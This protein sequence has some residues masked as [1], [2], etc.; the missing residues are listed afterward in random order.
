MEMWKLMSKKN[1]YA[2][3]EHVMNQRGD[4][5]AVHNETRNALMKILNEKEGIEFDEKDFW[6]TPE[7]KISVA[8]YK[9]LDKFGESIVALGLLL[10]NCHPMSKELLPHSLYLTPQCGEREL[11]QLLLEKFAKI[12]KK[13]IR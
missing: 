9:D 5:D 10:G 1:Q 3:L 2:Q 8:Y 11:H 4:L 13:L 12:N 7:T 6:P